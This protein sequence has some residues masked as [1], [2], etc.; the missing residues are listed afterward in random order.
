VSNG[1]VI[2]KRNMMPGDVF[3][4]RPSK[5]GN[6]FVIGKDGDRAEV[7]AKYRAWIADQPHLLAALP[8]L[9]GKRLACFCA[10]QACHGDVLAELVA[11][12]PD[13]AAPEGS[14]G[15]RSA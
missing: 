5:W 15:E 4:G 2:H 14:K 11:F 13:A 10:P 8:E 1:V 9:H 6:P 7:I 12:L 3:I